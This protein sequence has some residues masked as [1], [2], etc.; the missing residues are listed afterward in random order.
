M[1][2]RRRAVLDEF[3]GFVDPGKSKDVR[4]SVVEVR[5]KERTEVKEKMGTN[6]ATMDAS[7]GPPSR[8]VKL[9]SSWVWLE[10][11]MS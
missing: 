6:K 5:N 1:V 2:V 9:E 8:F 11:P 3:G 7:R 4:G 10:A